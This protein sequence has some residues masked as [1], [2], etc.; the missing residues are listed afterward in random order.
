M[1]ALAAFVAFCLLILILSV[2]LL[3]RE[4]KGE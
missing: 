4:G 2:W 3:V 1:T